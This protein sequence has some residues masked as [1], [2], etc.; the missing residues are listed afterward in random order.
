MRAT[1]CRQYYKTQTTGTLT[2]YDEETGEEVFKCR[3]LELAWLDNASNVSCIPEGFYDVVPRTSPKYGNHLHVTGVE[4][5]S[6][7]LIH[8][9]NFV[10]SNNPRTGHSDLRGCIAVG[11]KF[12]DITSDGIPEILNSKNTMKALM[13][14]ASDGFILEITQ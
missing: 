13:D 6:L 14:V 5:R 4:G 7:I 8:P 3:T 10:G 2:V 11:S 9:A 1:I 12:G